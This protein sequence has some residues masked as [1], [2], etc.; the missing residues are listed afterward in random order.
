MVDQDHQQAPPGALAEAGDFG[1]E[2]PYLL[3]RAELVH[4]Y[5]S[6][7]PDDQ[8]AGAR[9]PVLYLFHG[10]G[11]NEATWTAFGHAHL[12]ADNLL[13]QGKA[14]A[15]ITEENIPNIRTL[16]ENDLRVLQQF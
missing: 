12:I 15:M 8:D 7:R 3:K 13:A 10:S 5:P 1:H 16:F 11:D 14:R 4:S 6:Q 2:I 9:Y